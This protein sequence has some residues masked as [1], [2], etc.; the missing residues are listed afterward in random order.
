MKKTLV[1]GASTNPERYAYKA[2]KRL[3]EN[4]HEVIA[5]GNKAGKIDHTEI[6]TELDNVEDIHTITMYIGPKRQSDYFGTIE[7]I[8]PKRI[9]LNPGTENEEIIKLAEKNGIEVIQGCTLVMLST[10]QY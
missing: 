2:I 5:L 4:N 3:T 6:I 10:K 8:K 7:A 1:I 9:I